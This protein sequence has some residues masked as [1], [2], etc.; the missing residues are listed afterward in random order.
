MDKPEPLAMLGIH[1]NGRR[2][3]HREEKKQQQSTPQQ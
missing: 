3:K 1:D 2:R